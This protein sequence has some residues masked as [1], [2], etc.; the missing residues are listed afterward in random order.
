[1]WV[2][3]EVKVERWKMEVKR[4]YRAGTSW[5]IKGAVVFQAGRI[6]V[7]KHIFWEAQLYNIHSILYKILGTSR[8]KIHLPY[9]PPLTLCYECFKYVSSS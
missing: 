7:A 1:M 2:T 5:V 8:Y 4:H 3:L 9:L 6:A